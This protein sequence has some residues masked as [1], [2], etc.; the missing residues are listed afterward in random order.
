MCHPIVA[1]LR[2]IGL[3]DATDS[4]LSIRHLTNRRRP[5]K[6][7]NCIKEQFFLSPYDNNRKRSRTTSSSDESSRSKLSDDDSSCRDSTKDGCSTSIRDIILDANDNKFLNELLI[8]QSDQSTM[9][10]AVVEKS[11]SEKEHPSR[12]YYSAIA[13][14]RSDA[15]TRS[16]S[17]QEQGVKPLLLRKS[18][19]FANR[20]HSQSTSSDYSMDTISQNIE[21][22]VQDEYGVV[23]VC[24][25][26]EFRKSNKFEMRMS[27]SPLS[28][29]CSCHGGHG[30]GSG[31][32][33][34]R[35][36]RNSNNSEKN[37]KSGHVL[38][39]IFR[40]MRKISLGW[41]KSRCK[42]RRG[43]WVLFFFFIQI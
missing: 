42:I 12:K 32:G 39:R 35:S 10:S 4:E 30:G 5:T 28:H 16:K 37:Y 31:G 7:H 11:K 27:P 43:E 17:F 6:D 21:I 33:G 15:V 41:R 14:I 22:N 24:G 13:R 38:A 1:E 40:R 25:D 9:P 18:R 3:C 23:N 20:H 26:D 34:G 29:S 8:E 36:T 2:T 19:F